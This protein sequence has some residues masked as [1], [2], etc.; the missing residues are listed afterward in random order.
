MKKHRM[1]LLSV[2]AVAVGGILVAAERKQE[3]PDPVKIAASLKAPAGYDLTVFAYPPE[4]NYPTVVAATPG[5]G[6]F[7][8]IDEQG[9]LGKTPGK[10]RVVYCPDEDGDGRA[11]RVIEFAKMD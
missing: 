9:S 8:G 4:V 2:A 3:P 1:R 7:V 11:D 5:G 6:L 10:G